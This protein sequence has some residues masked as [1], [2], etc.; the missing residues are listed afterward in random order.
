MASPG[1]KVQPGRGDERNRGARRPLRDRK[2]AGE[3]GQTGLP[4]ARRRRRPTRKSRPGLTVLHPERCPRGRR[5][6]QG[7][8]ASRCQRPPSRRGSRPPE[9]WTRV[10]SRT[11]W[12]RPS[13]TRATAKLRERRSLRPLQNLR[14]SHSSFQGPRLTTPPWQTPSGAPL[15]H[16]AHSP[17]RANRPRPYPI[18]QARPKRLRDRTGRQRPVRTSIPV[19]SA[20]PRRRAHLPRDRCS[21]SPG[22]SNR[23]TLAANS[24]ALWTV[25]WRQVK[26]NCAQQW[27]GTGSDSSRPGG[28]LARPACC[29]R[30]PLPPI[31]RCHPAA[32]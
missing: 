8:G 9:D 10:T 16:R 11:Q 2:T 5:A 1:A 24:S 30:V 18:R 7:T 6:A 4:R 15:A 17:G 21:A 27:T 31:Y 26:T 29:W 19:R 3:C 13:V 12:G 32:C 25:V 20:I 23:R 28:T 22:R 14:D